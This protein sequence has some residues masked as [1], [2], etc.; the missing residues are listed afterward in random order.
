[1]EPKEDKILEEPIS[2]YKKRCKQLLKEKQELELE[3]AVLQ[4]LLKKKNMS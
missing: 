4:D 2:D 3:V 1:M